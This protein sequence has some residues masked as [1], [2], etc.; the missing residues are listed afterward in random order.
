MAFSFD[1]ACVAQWAEQAQLRKRA[2]NKKILLTD[3]AGKVQVHPT[4][5][6]LREN[7]N[8]LKAYTKHMAS[9]GV[10]HTCIEA[11]REPITR[12]YR[13]NAPE[14]NM[15]DDLRLVAHGSAFMAKRMLCML[16]RK[17]K[18]AE[19]PR[20]TCLHAVIPFSLEK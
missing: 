7:H 14:E 15:G 12:F 2:V 4:L 10:I 5:S 9:A 1:D 11:V 20:D 3:V 18:R 6:S 17:W 19:F 16:K 13:E 8:L